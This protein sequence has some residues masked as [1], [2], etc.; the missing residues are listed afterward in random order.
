M[1]W[2]FGLYASYVWEWMHQARELELDL[3]RWD[4]ESPAFTHEE[5]IEYA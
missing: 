5:T 4:G 2:V 3:I 1:P